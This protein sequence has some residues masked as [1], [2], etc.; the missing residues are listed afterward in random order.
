MFYNNSRNP[1]LAAE[2]FLLFIHF[3]IAGD[4]FYTEIK[5]NSG[6]IDGN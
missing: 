2:R 4:L 3:L 1:F 6:R 5:R